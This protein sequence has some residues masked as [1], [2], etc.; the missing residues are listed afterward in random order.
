VFHWVP[1]EAAQIGADGG[2]I[3]VGEGAG[4]F[5]VVK[6]NDLDAGAYVTPADLRLRAGEASLGF[7]RRHPFPRNESDVYL[8][9]SFPGERQ[10]NLA[11]QVSRRHSPSN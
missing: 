11:H 10:L 8:I 5:E 1:H 2:V 6:V 9:P 4:R 7:P 3:V